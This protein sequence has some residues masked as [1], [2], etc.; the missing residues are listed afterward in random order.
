MRSR[1]RCS[2][3]CRIWSLLGP[4]PPGDPPLDDELGDGLGDGLGGLLFDDP[5][6]LL[7]VFREPEV[8]TFTRGTSALNVLD[9]AEALVFCSSTTLIVRRAARAALSIDS[10]SDRT[11]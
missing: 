3:N 2:K 9:T 10:T 11:C 6:L 7:L 1:I 5:L 4:P 8:L